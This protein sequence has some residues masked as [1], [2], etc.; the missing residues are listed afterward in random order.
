[1]KKLFFS[2]IGVFASL[3]AFSQDV[4]FMGTSADIGRETA[5]RVRSLV[6]ATIEIDWGNGVREPLHLDT[7]IVNVFPG[8][9]GESGKVTVYGDAENLWVFSIYDA[10]FTEVDLS[11][12]VNAT[13]LGFGGNELKSVDLSAN[14]KLEELTLTG[15]PMEGLD[16]SMLGELRHLT[17]PN[18]GFTSL[19]V[20]KNSKLE[21]L[22]IGSNPLKSIDVSNNPELWDLQCSGCG[23]ESL[24]LS[25]NPKMRQ[26]ICN[27]NDLTVLDISANPDM[28]YLLCMNNYLTIGTLPLFHPLTDRSYKYAPQKPLPMADTVGGVDFSA[29]YDC[30][31]YTTRYTWRTE[32]GRTLIDGIDYTMKNGITNF[33]TPGLKVSGQ[34]ENDF[35]PL[36]V[37][38]DACRTEFFITAIG[39]V[40]NEPA[41]LDGTRAYAKAGRICMESE[42]DARL[43]IYNLSGQRLLEGKVDG[44][45]EWTAPVPGLYL[46]RM[47]AGQAVVVHKVNVF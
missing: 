19:D 16:V 39:H 35:F 25:H 8:Q 40:D 44:Y 13:C 4:V 29:G 17:V 42:R 18:C 5:L 3:V 46:V 10:G 37:G 38:E 7:S 34:M 20:S 24:D 33:L 2:L 32:E 47:Q 14:L 41:V 9:I 28:T 12:L 27:D 11:A 43:E 26:L 36:L 21:N 22:Y 6:P 45:Q 31:G 1:M 23:L 30:E 15:N